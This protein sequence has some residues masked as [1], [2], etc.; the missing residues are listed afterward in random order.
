M[1]KQIIM[2]L[3]FAMGLAIVSMSV[4]IAAGL[5]LAHT[6]ANQTATSPIWAVLVITCISV[7][8]V[9]GIDRIIYITK[10]NKRKVMK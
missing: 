5:A 6:T 4:A 3:A 10:T 8:I 1:N 2:P 9:A 7:L